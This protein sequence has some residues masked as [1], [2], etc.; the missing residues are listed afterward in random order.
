MQS[1]DNVNTVLGDDLKAEVRPGSK[2]R[3]AAS[4]FSIYAFEAL[5]EELESVSELQFVFTDPSFSSASVHGGTRREHRTYFIPPLA[6]EGGLTGT[7]FEVRL[8]NRLTQRAIAR[9]CADWVRRKV[10]LRSNVSGMG[11]QPMI[12][13]DEVAYFPVSGFTTSALGY[14]ESD[15][16]SNWVTKMDRPEEASSFLSIFDQVWNDPE[17]L[18]DVT[19]TVL[20]HIEQVY[21]ENSPERIYFIILNSIFADFLA[22]ISEDVLPDDR[23]GY[24]DTAVWR[25][26]YDFQRDAAEGIINKLETYN[27]C[28]LADSV[29]LGKTFTALAVIKYYE[30]RNRSVLVLCPKKLAENWTTYNKNYVTNPFVEDRFNYDVLAHT[31]LSRTR[32][33]S[34]GIRLDQVN[35][36]NY[37]L[38]VID[39]SHN[40]RNADYSEDRDTRYQRL[41]DKVIR[42]GV[43]TKVLML[44]ATP[45][46]NRFTDLKNQLQL[47]YE[48]DESNLSQHLS[49]STTIDGVF[50]QAQAV[51]NEWSRLPAEERTSERIL[52]M[53]DFDFF[54][55]LDAVTIARSRKHIQKFYD[56]TAVG[57]FPRRLPPV[58]LQEPLT[59]DTSVPSFNE[60]FEQLRALNLSVYTPL[61]FV[62]ESRLYKYET[63]TGEENTDNFRAGRGQKGRE[64]G[65]QQLM[66]VNLLKRL[67]SSVDAF[68]KT[69]LS[70]ES[71]VD[72][73]LTRLE[74]ASADSLDFSRAAID[75][76]ILR[77]DDDVVETV[78][79]MPGDL[80]LDLRDVDVLS[81][82]EALW[83]DR[84]TLRELIGE[85]RKITPERD[86]KLQRL[87]QLVLDKAAAPINPGN[88]KVLV[89]SAFADTAAYL[90]EQLSPVFAEAGLETGIIVGGANGAKSTL[91]PGLDYQTLMTLFSPVSKKRDAVFPG[92]TRELDVL[93]GTD[94]ISEGQ[95]LQDCDYLVNYDI[96]WNPVR[97]V[98]RFGRVDRIGSVNEK[99]QLVNFWPDITLDEYINLK[100]RVENRMVIVDVTGTADDNV[101]TPQQNDAQYRTA[102]LQRMQ[103]EVIDLEDTQQGVSITDLGLNDFRSSLMAYTREHGDLARAPRGL[104]AVIPADPA[105]G[106]PPGVIFALHNV[107]ADSSM[108]RGNRLHPY[109]LVYMGDDGATV[110][111][112]TQAKPLLDLLRSAAEGRSEPC[113]NAVE[114]FNGATA[115]GVRMEHYSDLLTRAVESMVDVTEEQDVASLFTPG[116][117]TALTQTIQGLDDFHLIA[118]IAVVEEGP[119][120][121]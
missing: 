49:L 62:H 90:Y 32:G 17:K 5:R 96:H 10:T 87:K 111:D 71:Q 40:F 80:A 8:R 93:I 34:L 41:M 53:L 118:F 6:G 116:P 104:H 72:A 67:E 117:T 98:Q 47:A 54:E 120:D 1:I 73:L 86:L 63:G 50:R 89:F 9:E 77:E 113:T 112:H 38:V 27:G 81:W 61:A 70:I 36:G 114:V 94:V 33:E 100:D 4:V 69:L 15:Q 24:R 16:L 45:V 84:E 95:N 20:A 14:E 99:I 88:R 43:R 46:N 42:E 91:G 107:N 28:I 75:A 18:E 58:S 22:D 115:E 108:H 83:H 48:G 64:A 82:K 76:D 19:D 74:S 101:L 105:N 39:E 56:T 78:F 21:A 44:S 26:L 121:G 51:F 30:K 60:I 3:L 35:W 103:T 2:V 37:G 29:G 65:L 11:M 66:T 106:L 52:A 109:Y 13:V 59:D 92:E 102:Q 79:S 23:T 25:A 55:L 68:R 110:L 12:G 85:M 31:D 119:A 97:I 57:A 7:E